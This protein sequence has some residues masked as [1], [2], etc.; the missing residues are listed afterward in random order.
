MGK[1][2]RKLHRNKYHFLSQKHFV[3]S[4][5]MKIGFLNKKVNLFEH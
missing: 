2:K 4:G 5:F 3:V 1:I